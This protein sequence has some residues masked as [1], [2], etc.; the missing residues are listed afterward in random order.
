[1]KGKLRYSPKF[2]GSTKVIWRLIQGNNY[3]NTSKDII[4]DI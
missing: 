3:N 2:T 4:Y 1:M